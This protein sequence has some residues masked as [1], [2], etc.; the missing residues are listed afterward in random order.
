MNDRELRGRLKESLVAHQGQ[1]PP[2][3]DK[4]WSA[5]EMQYLEGRRLYAAFSGIAAVVAVVAVVAGLWSADEAMLADE[6]LIA[7]S[8]LNETQW[9][10]PSDALLPQHRFDIYREVPFPM[11]LTNPDEGSLL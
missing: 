8:L 6:F 1:E 10:A 3:F 2:A 9:S 11:E 4:V 7:D 5:A